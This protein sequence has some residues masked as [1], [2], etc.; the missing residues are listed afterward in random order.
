MKKGPVVCIGASLIDESYICHSQPV[1]G[2]SN[3][4]TYYRS[5]GGVARNIANHLALLGN[6]VELITHFGTDPGGLWLMEQC[7]EAG[8][9]LSHA[10]VNDN[11]TGRFVAMLT[12]EGDLFAGA[13][14][15]SFENMIT[16][17]FLQQKAALIRSASLLLLDTNLSKTCLN[18]LLQFCREEKVPCVVEPVSVPKA[19]RLL[20]ADISGV[21]LVTPNQDEMLAITGSIRNTEPEILINQVLER[22]VQYVWK[23]AGKEGSGVYSRGFHYSLPAP[24]ADV[25]DTTGAGDAALAG[26][27]HAWLNGRSIEDCLV[28]GHAMASI[29]LQVKGAVYPGLTMNQL[30]ISYRKLTKQYESI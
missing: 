9:G 12:P 6:N 17:E 27:I 11:E 18:W 16:T 21:M 8:I 30:E 26:W 29:I 15:C 22:G 5:P 7:S 20:N 2:T 23:R 10:F 19:A 3:I 28:Y 4:A 25:T 1:A 13:V 14:S 24:E